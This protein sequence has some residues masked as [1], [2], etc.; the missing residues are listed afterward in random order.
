MD[1]FFIYYNPISDK[2]PE[3][4][5]LTGIR[6]DKILHFVS[7]PVDAKLSIQNLANNSFVTNDPNAGLLVREWQRLNPEFK[8]YNSTVKTNLPFEE[9]VSEAYDSFKKFIGSASNILLLGLA[10]YIA[11]KLFD[12]KRK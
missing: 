7:I 9:E 11:I 1:R 2:E 5:S 6:H 12:S 4:P 3:T 8:I 10:G